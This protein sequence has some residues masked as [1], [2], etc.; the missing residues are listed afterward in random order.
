M[1]IDT[2]R[3]MHALLRKG[4]EA[5]VAATLQILTAEIDGEAEH[6]RHLQDERNQREHEQFG[7]PLPTPKD[8]Q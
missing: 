3:Y 8:T 5:S 7:I 1:D 2:V 6:E 4:D